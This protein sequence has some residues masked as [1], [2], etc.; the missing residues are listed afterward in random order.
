MSFPEMENEMLKRITS[1]PVWHSF[2]TNPGKSLSAFYFTGKF[3][4]PS[5]F[6]PFKMKKSQSFI[7]SGL[8]I[9]GGLLSAGFLFMACDKSND[10]I[11]DT[12][13]AALMAFNL[14]T[15]QPAIGVAL[16]GNSLTSV[17]LEYSGYTGGYRNIYTGNRTIEAFDASNNNLL[18][19]ASFTF[20]K[21]KFYSTFLIGANNNYS[22]I[23]A[24]DNFDSLS[25]GSGMAYVRYINAIPD[26]SSPTVIIT[27]NAANVV[28]ESAGFR[29][30]SEF[31]PANPG[32]ITISVNNMGNIDA[33]RT[34]SIAAKKA[35]T[36]LLIG[37]P[38]NA[39]AP[40]EIRY[41]ENGTLTDEVPEE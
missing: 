31:V 7:R 14:A 2:P 21:N 33:S 36:I 32:E 18:A 38:E 35:Y 5:P 17:P 9:F 3:L 13:A 25:A 10:D 22:T 34:I 16:S 6:K 20:E 23:V 29:K 30:I 40:V 15:D 24:H 39:S 41:I 28:D 8:M 27:A 12:P 37:D 1:L 26:S 11:P 19:S 4:F